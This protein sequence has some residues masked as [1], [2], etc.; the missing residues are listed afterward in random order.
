M[1]FSPLSEM[2]RAR[3]A[4]RPAPPLGG[5]PRHRRDLLSRL[6]PERRP[7]VPQA[8]EHE[9]AQF[10]VALQPRSG[11]WRPQNRSPAGW[12]TTRLQ[13]ASAMKASIASSMPRSGAPTTVPGGTIFP[14]PKP[15]AAGAAVKADRPRAQSRAASP[16]PSAPRWRTTTPFQDAGKLTSCSSKPMARPSWSPSPVSSSSPDSQTKLPNPPTFLAQLFALQM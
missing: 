5:F 2:V 11:P 3:E 16:S 7:A 14:G 8:G 10:A 13:P 4:C 1:T 9:A 15:T 6:L 12:P